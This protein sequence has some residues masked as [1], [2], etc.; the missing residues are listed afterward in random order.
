V[1]QFSTTVISKDK[2]EDLIFGMYAHSRF[3]LKLLNK[4][5]IYSIAHI[6]GKEQS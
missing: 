4:A 5:I 2:D 1:Q 6:Q 3:E